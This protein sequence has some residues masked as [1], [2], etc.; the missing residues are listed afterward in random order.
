M[1]R[2]GR[3]T[4]NKKLSMDY[5]KYLTHKIPEQWDGLKQIRQ[6]GYKLL[7]QRSYNCFEKFL[8]DIGDKPLKGE[9]LFKK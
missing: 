1:Y 9:G 5:K 4:L 6:V 2:H 3:E 8:V 7:E